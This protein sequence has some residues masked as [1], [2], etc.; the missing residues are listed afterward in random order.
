MWVSPLQAD[1]YECVHRVSGDR[2]W[3]NRPCDPSENRASFQVTTP[4][5]V[6]E[7]PVAVPSAPN[8]PSTAA[9]TVPGSPNQHTLPPTPGDGPKPALIQPPVQQGAPVPP[10]ANAPG[11]PSV[12]PGTPGGEVTNLSPADL[13]TP[14]SLPGTDLAEVDQVLMVAKRKTESRD[15]LVLMKFQFRSSKT[16]REIQWEAKLKKVLA[17]CFLYQESESPNADVSTLG[18]PLSQGSGL[19]GSW[20]ETFPL[21]FPK[22]YF[23][24]VKKT[25]FGRIECDFELPNGKRAHARTIALNKIPLNDAKP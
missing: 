19:L 5:P 6:K 24:D 21:Y 18:K 13:V 16:N 3:R 7:K 12:A 1:I 17:S 20:Q 25:V 4:D 9:S 8:A 14:S 2:V 10:I 22:N 23:A 11:V 15:G